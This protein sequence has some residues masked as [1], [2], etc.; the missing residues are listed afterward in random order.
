MTF[1]NARDCDQLLSLLLLFMLIDWTV[2]LN[3][4]KL[5]YKYCQTEYN[6][7]FS[8][9]KNQLKVNDLGEIFMNN[10]L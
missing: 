2:E 7:C 6:W 9:L 5:K 3:G 4:F 8:Q 1:Q 10:K